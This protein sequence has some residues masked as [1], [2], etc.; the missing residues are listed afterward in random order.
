MPMRRRCTPHSNQPPSPLM[1]PGHLARPLRPVQSAARGGS[2]VPPVAAARG[3]EPSPGTMAD[4]LAACDGVP[5]P[6]SRAPLTP[7][8]PPSSPTFSPLLDATLL[9]AVPPPRA[10]TPPPTAAAL[11]PSIRA[12]APP[13]QGGASGALQTA[14]TT[15]TTLPRQPRPAAS[16]PTGGRRH[17]RMALPGVRHAARAALTVAQLATFAEQQAVAH[18]IDAVRALPVD[19]MHLYADAA[20]VEAH[21]LEAAQQSLALQLHNV[22]ARVRNALVAKAL[23]RGVSVTNSQ[24]DSVLGVE[25]DGKASSY[26]AFYATRYDGPAGPAAAGDDGSYAI[27]V[28]VGG[29]DLLVG[30][31]VVGWE[32]SRR[33]VQV[34]TR[35]CHCLVGGWGCAACPILNDEVTRR[36]VL[37]RHALSL[38][39][40]TSLHR[41][42]VHKAVQRAR[43]LGPRRPAGA[44]LSQPTASLAGTP[45]WR[46][47]SRSTYL[48][49]APAR[50]TPRIGDGGMGSPDL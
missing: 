10:G 40:Q 47:P 21:G 3:K 24:E 11:P 31:E 44:A 26:M 36:P 14:A 48:G 38:D 30:E 50:G 16:A 46:A 43:L 20:C 5:V 25:R 8:A 34:A 15:T 49:T 39:K 33:A 45:G 35:P 17:P 1:S 13:L 23:V 4:V 29:V 32:T 2:A 41:W 37:A 42:M 27:C 19:T 28:M 12:T 22:P 9:A 7:A 18:N 6:A